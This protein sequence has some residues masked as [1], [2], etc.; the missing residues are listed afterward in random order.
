MFSRQEE[1]SSL[2][3]S[4]ELS[5]Q[6][7]EISNQISVITGWP[8]FGSVKVWARNDLRGP[9]FSV[10]TVPL[11]KGFSLHLSALR[12]RGAVPVSVPEKWF[13][14]FPVLVS[15][16]GKTVPVSADFP[17]LVSGVEQPLHRKTGQVCE[18]C[19]GARV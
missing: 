17:A 2:Q 13:L 15:V 16:P 3:I 19:S 7:F 1:K 11:G 8:R 9:G 5:H 10:R 14:P 6:I 4:P 18:L 12:E